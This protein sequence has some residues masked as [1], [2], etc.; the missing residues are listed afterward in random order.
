M[1]YSKNQYQSMI[2]TYLQ[3]KEQLKKKDKIKYADNIKMLSKKIKTWKLQVYRLQKRHDIIKGLMKSVNYF[4]GVDIRLRKKDRKHNLARNVFYKYGM[5]NRLRGA[6]LCLELGRTR[7]KTTS[8]CRMKFTKSFKTKPE[9]KQAYID[10]KN[11][12]ATK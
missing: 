9:N 10:F 6:W 2:H 12:H 11:Y 8:E 3:R 7:F 5:E 4:F 1:S